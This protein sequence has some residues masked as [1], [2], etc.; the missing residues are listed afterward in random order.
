MKKRFLK[1]ILSLLV[2]V[3]AISMLSMTAAASSAEE[4][5]ERQPDHTR[6]GSASVYI[7]EADGKAVPGGSITIFT[8]ADAVFEGGNN[9]FVCR[10]EFAACGLDLQRIDPEGSGAPD[11]ARE[12]ADWAL[13][14][15]IEGREK[16]IDENGRAVFED[17]SLGLYLFIQKTPAIG[18]EC[19]QPFLVTVPLWDGQKLVY[20]VEAGPKAGTAA[21]LAC[22]EPS[23]KKVFRAGKGTLPKGETF[24]FRMVPGDREYPM[25]A[26]EGGVRDEKTGAVTVNHGAGTFTFGKIWFGTEDIGRTYTYTISE[27]AGKNRKITYDRT[28]YRL[29]VEVVKNEESGKTECRTSVSGDGK[30]AAGIVFTNV[31]DTP[32]APGKPGKPKLPQTGQLWWPVPL[33]FLAGIMLLGMGRIR[34]RSSK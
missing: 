22:I 23:V 18:Y 15:G 5:A 28:V 11:L 12:L 6:K 13:E 24:N 7:R 27:L 31:Y 3:L 25:P 32:P 33:L 8:V 4:H 30:K 10:E 9:L 14:K 21:G 34:S 19:V 2:S 29:K 17:L 26:P 16:E 20:D 1:K